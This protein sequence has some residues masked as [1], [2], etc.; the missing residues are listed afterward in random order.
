MGYHKGCWFILTAGRWS[1][2]LKAAEECVTTHQPNEPALKMGSAQV[3]DQYPTIAATL[4]C[5]RVGERGVC[6]AASGASLGGT[7]AGADLGGSSKYSSG[8]FEDWGGAGLH[9]NSSW[10]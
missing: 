3:G 2:K 4:V 5:Q 10:T 9:A 6:H 7:N 1:W 8:N